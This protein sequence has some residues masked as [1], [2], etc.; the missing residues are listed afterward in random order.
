MR[1]KKIGA[2]AT[3]LARGAR[4]K[5]VKTYLGAGS[6][7]R[8]GLD[9]A[10]SPMISTPHWHW[11]RSPISSTPSASPDRHQIAF[12]DLHNFTV[13]ARPDRSEERRVGKECRSR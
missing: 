5:V 6:P 13:A 7:T 11:W 12:A 9:V 10:G 1:N 4:F 2:P 3:K 8:A